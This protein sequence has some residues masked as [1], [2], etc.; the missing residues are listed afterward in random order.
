MKK[1]SEIPCQTTNELSASAAKVPSHLSSKSG[2]S[3]SRNMLLVVGLMTQTPLSASFVQGFTSPS[4][5]SRS[6]HIIPRDSSGTNS[7]LYQSGVSSDEISAQLERAKALIAKSKAKI[8]ERNGE[9]SG[10]EGK[11]KGSVPFFANKDRSNKKDQVIKNMDENTGLFTTDGDKMAEL[12]EEEEWESRP[13]LEVFE[14]EIEDTSSSVL[15]ER[16]VAASIF[17]LRKTLQM[18]DYRKIFDKRNRFIGEDN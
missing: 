16:D 9:D 4:S 17:N 5:S 14:S 10:N 6:H 8:E 2:L 18:E 15:N 1:T 12:S 7:C 11:K 3:R 13:L